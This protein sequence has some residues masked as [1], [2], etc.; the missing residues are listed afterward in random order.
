MKK[1]EVCEETPDTNKSVSK[2]GEKG[3]NAT[4]NPQDKQCLY[5]KIKHGHIVRGLA[6]EDSSIHAK[7]FAQLVFRFDPMISTLVVRRETAGSAFMDLLVSTGGFI[8]ALWFLVMPVAKN[9]SSKLYD[10]NL[11]S[12]LYLNKDEPEIKEISEKDNKDME[13]I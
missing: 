9:I 10:A 3:K 13:M 7:V 12:S 5:T 6:G 4:T 11:I 1:S 2:V 8:A